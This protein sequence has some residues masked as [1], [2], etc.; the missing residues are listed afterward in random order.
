MTLTKPYH[1]VHQRG[2]WYKDRPA[3]F[4][5]IF[6]TRALAISAIEQH[7]RLY[8]EKYSNDSQAEY[9]GGPG[10][11]IYIITQ[12]GCSVDTTD[13]T[14]PIRT[15]FLA[16]HAKHERIIES[17]ICATKDVA[18][19]ACAEMNPPNKGD[20][21]WLNFKEWTDE[22]G[23]QHGEAERSQVLAGI[24][25]VVGMGVHHWYVKEFVVNKR[26]EFDVD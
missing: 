3:R 19:A 6:S 5:G 23:C 4:L 14:S 1:V 17:R 24:A 15:I 9:D 13:P 26:E 8:V 11:N 7:S 20:P 22:Q 16:I 12:H 21:R 2:L 18:W 25:G 10:G